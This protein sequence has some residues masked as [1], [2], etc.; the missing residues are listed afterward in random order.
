MKL[1]W[2]VKTCYFPF[3]LAEI[4]TVMGAPPGPSVDPFLAE[5][6]VNGRDKMGRRFGE[7]V[8][9]EGSFPSLLTRTAEE[10]RRKWKTQNKISYF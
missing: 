3:P 5:S 10:Q 9:G 8:W 6:Q 7:E 4:S 2:A 1:Y